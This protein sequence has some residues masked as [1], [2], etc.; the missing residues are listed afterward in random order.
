MAEAQQKYPTPVCPSSGS[1]HG[2]EGG[3]RCA[4]ASSLLLGFSPLQSLGLHAGET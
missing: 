3:V 2:S 1:R 4:D